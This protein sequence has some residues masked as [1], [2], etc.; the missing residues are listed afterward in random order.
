MS[1]IR[2]L[3]YLA[4][5]WMIT[6]IG[7]NAFK[8]TIV[9]APA[10]TFYV[11]SPSLLDAIEQ[12]DSHR[13]GMARPSLIDR[14]TGIRTP[15]VL[16]DDLSWDLLSVSPWC[17]EDGKAQAVARWAN[18]VS[19]D[20]EQPF[21]GL[22]LLKLPEATVAG[23]IA[24]DVLPTGRACFVPGQV[25]EVLFPAG[26]GRLY[27]A[28]FCGNTSG[29]R[30]AGAGR[31]LADGDHASAAIRPLAW[32]CP[33]PADGNVLL[34]DPVWPSDQRLRHL[35]FISFTSQK[36]PPPR[37]FF[38][39]PK[40]W[41]LELNEQGDTIRRAGPL[42]EIRNSKS[43]I[44][45]GDAQGRDPKSEI[46]NGDAQG[47]NA[48]SEIRNGEAQGRDPKSEM[49]NRPLPDRDADA[50]I[51]GAP[52]RHGAVKRAATIGSAVDM[53]AQRFPTV[54]VRRSGGL[55]LVYLSQR[56]GASRVDLKWARLEVDATTGVP[57][58]GLSQS[59]SEASQ[60]GLRLSPPVVAA[61][62]RSVFA[63]NRSGALV[64][65]ELPDAR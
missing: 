35:V 13:P 62:G 22:G 41:W 23:R 51:R 14:T 7:Y 3:V 31:S 27:R 61:D 1:W 47:R 57:S 21:C 50:E 8:R 53:T 54:V 64:R 9:A 2:L 12:L 36:M 60:E 4:V 44:R 39:P 40:L 32:E 48:K 34:A 11:P 10:L 24:T 56:N 30:E 37:H 5:A 65:F 52:F 55:G 20:G 38:E 42:G 6:A 59:L 45:N 15:I 25:G 16:P 63:A 29:G 49:R 26:D 43:E 28:T 33:A 58:I 18:Y 46:R 19:E 17:D